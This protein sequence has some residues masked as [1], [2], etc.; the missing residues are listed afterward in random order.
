MKWNEINVDVY[1]PYLTYEQNN[2]NG[3]NLPT[4][5]LPVLVY[6]IDDSKVGYFVG[7]FYKQEPSNRICC[8]TPWNWNYYHVEN[9]KWC[10]FEF[11]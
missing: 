7:R 11:V 3:M 2:I 8:S 4:E 10:A 5:W 6:D 9:L 1:N